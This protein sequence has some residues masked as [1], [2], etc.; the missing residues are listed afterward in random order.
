MTLNCIALTRKADNGII[1][2]PYSPE[3]CSDIVKTL[4]ENGFN[5]YIFSK[6]KVLVSVN[7]PSGEEKQKVIAHLRSLAEQARVAIRN[8]RRAYRDELKPSQREE[9]LMKRF[10]RLMIYWRI[11]LIHYEV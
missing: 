10:F 4:K 9:Q 8:S 7:P 2:E 3:D 5:A 11:R 1:V 6:G